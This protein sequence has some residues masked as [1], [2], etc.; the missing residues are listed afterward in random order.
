MVQHSCILST[1]GSLC[2]SV[3]DNIIITSVLNSLVVNLVLENM[4]FEHDSKVIF[5][6]DLREEMI[7]FMTKRKNNGNNEKQN[8]CV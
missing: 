1:S 6:H 3:G 8:V 2:I 7:G 5:F 4:Y